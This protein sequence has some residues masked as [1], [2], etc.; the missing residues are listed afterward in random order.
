MYARETIRGFRLIDAFR[1]GF[2]RLLRGS[3][4]VPRRS[5]R[6][7][8]V[9]RLCLRFSFRLCRARLLNAGV[10]GLSLAELTG[11]R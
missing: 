1:R 4:I 8:V 9:S 3:L 10:H 7:G 6:T 5:R 11:R 2:V